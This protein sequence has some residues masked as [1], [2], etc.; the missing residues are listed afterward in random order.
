[1]SKVVSVNYTDTPISGVSSLNFPR[2]LVNFGADFKKKEDEPKEAM[3][4]NLTSPISFPEKFRFGITEIADVYKGAGIEPGMYA[5]TRRGTQILS[6]VTETWT[7]TD[8]SDATYQ[9]A[10]PVGCHVIVR[11]PNN[12]NITPAMVQTLV[13]RA[14][15]G[16]FETGSLST[17]RLAA[18]LRG[19]LLPSDI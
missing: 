3:I 16:L 17:S 2:G 5:P 15:S 12:E 19:S 1:M 10:L 7:V 18:M 6:Q 14:V 9:V 11:I 8:S 13:G 4:T